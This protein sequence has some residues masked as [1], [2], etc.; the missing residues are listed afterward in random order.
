MN[1][2]VNRVM[3]LLKEPGPPRALI[4]IDGPCG[5]GKSTLAAALAR[6]TGA[7]VVVADFDNMLEGSSIKISAEGTF[8]SAMTD[9]DE[10]IDYF[11][12]DNAGDWIIVRDK[13]FYQGVKTE[14]T[15]AEQTDTTFFNK[16]S[17]GYTPRLPTFFT[18]FNEL[19]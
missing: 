15:A 11:T 4:T 10:W 18:L 8:S 14:V 19:S 16:K 1:T 5:S 3:P 2:L 6:A 9:A 13:A 17:P 12:T 7:P